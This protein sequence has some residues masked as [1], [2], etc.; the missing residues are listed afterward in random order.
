MGVMYPVG[1]EH[2][3]WGPST[4]FCCRDSSRSRSSGVGRDVNGEKKPIRFG[5]S[6]RFGGLVTLEVEWGGDESGWTQS[7]VKTEWGI[8]GCTHRGLVT[9]GVEWD[10][11]G[12]TTQ[13]VLSLY[14]VF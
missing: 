12:G 4:F 2:P 7:R 3:F 1:T 9:L 8:F 14:P 5:S 13:Q 11:W 10:E 6:N